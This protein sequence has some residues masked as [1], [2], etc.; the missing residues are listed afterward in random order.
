M[1]LYLKNVHKQEKKSIT[2]CI[3][4]QCSLFLIFNNREHCVRYMF[5]D[6]NTNACIAAL[7]G[8]E[9]DLL[10]NNVC[11]ETNL[12]GTDICIFLITNN[13]FSKVF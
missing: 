9:Y 5:H 12:S 10:A 7:F 11:D 6:D 4:L 2:F 1:F 8:F 3:D 13:T